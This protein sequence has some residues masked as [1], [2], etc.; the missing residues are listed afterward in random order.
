MQGVQQVDGLQQTAMQQR[1]T[2]GCSLHVG[3]SSG[4][5]SR[6]AALLSDAEAGKASMQASEQLHAARGSGGVTHGGLL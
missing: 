2:Q 1:A 3:C 6:R 5:C 4:T